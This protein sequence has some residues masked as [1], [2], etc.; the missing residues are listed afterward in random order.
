MISFKTV[1]DLDFERKRVIVRLDFNV[2]LDECGKVADRSRIKAGVPTIKY[3]LSKKPSKVIL[4]SHLGRPD[5]KIVESLRMDSVAEELQKSLKEKVVKLDDCIGVKS[6]ID[7]S[8]EKIFLL[9][10]LRFYPEEE[11][12]DVSFAKKL[13]EVADIYVNDAFGACHRA[14][15]SVS[16]IT[17]FLPSCAG[18]LLQKEIESLSGLFN[19]KRPFIIVL[20]GAKVSDKVGVI[21][22][23]GGKAD[24]LLI[25][26]AMAFTFLKAKGIS[27][28]KSKVDPGKMAFALRLLKYDPVL[29][30]DF[31]VA[32][33][34]DSDAKA[35]VSS[36]IP[37]SSLGL[38]I[39]PET[40]KS[41]ISE[42]CRAKTIVWN[43]PMGVFEIEKFSKGTKDIGRAIS[44]CRGETVVGGGDTLAAVEKFRLKGFTHLS[45]GGGAMLEFL[46]GKKLPAIEALEKS[47][48]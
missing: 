44:K 11:N 42:I 7:S 46:E 15:A 16:A 10:N 3:I 45:T 28:G 18:L 12:N 6:V 39:G 33:K 31:V 41:F 27:V 8:D 47:V 9:E 2:A 30:D 32:D 25:G 4:M 1:K 24:R 13:S 40:V 17:Q 14:H 37:E 23:L 34:M 43:G 20:G 22:N 21:E 29:P 26:G 48:K 36:S 38:D 35:S 5:G 19:P